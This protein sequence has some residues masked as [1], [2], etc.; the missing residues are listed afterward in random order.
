[1]VAAHRMTRRHLLAKPVRLPGRVRV[2]VDLVVHCCCLFHKNMKC[3]PDRGR[4]DRLNICSPEKDGAFSMIYGG[5]NG[6]A[7]PP[8]L[9]NASRCLTFEFRGPYGT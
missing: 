8:P 9:K 7:V 2:D 5:K 3:Q 1:M 6:Y 4:G